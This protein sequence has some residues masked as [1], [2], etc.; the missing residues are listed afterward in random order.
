M[1]CNMT[2]R[3]AAWETSTH[4][5][6]PH[7]AIAPMMGTSSFNFWDTFFLGRICEAALCF[8][9]QIVRL[10]TKIFLK[11]PVNGI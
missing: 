3:L 11:N 5:V 2:L 4:R 6:Q 7:T 1:L 10:D 8:V 9:A